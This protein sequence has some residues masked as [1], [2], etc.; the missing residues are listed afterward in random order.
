[1]SGYY[2]S[3]NAYSKMETSKLG[4]KNCAVVSDRNE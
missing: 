2:S 3:V 1:M 4:E